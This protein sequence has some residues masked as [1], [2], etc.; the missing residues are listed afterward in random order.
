MNRMTKDAITVQLRAAHCE[1][2]AALAPLVYVSGAEMFEYL[3]TTRRCAAQDF[4]RAALH[5]GRGLLGWPYHCVALHEARIVASMALYDTADLTRLAQQ[6]L[7]QYLR[8]SHP[9]YAAR[10]LLRVLRLGAVQPYPPPGGLYIAHLSVDADL[11]GRGIGRQ[12]LEHALQRARARGHAYCMLD[13]AQDNVAACALYASCGFVAIGP[14]L[15][16]P[17][18][19]GV[20]HSLRMRCD[21]RSA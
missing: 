6:T 8:L 15:V 14:P 7:W 10:V 13:V 20:P 11:R 9:F 1:D 12:L 21:L 5:D 17:R 18:D 19:A 3:F 16:S 2:A 4:L